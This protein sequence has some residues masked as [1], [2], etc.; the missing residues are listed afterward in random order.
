M[1]PLVCIFKSSAEFDFF[2]LI[3]VPDDV[4]YKG[5]KGRTHWFLLFVSVIMVGSYSY[6]RTI[7][8][9][10]CIIFIDLKHYYVCEYSNMWYMEAI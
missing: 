9:F 4:T 5:I 3:N 2:L 7:T 8:S 6:S 1:C 10:S